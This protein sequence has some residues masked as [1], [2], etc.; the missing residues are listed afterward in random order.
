M[1]KIIKI[2]LLIFF[3]YQICFNFLLELKLFDNNEDFIIQ[4]IKYMD[5]KDEKNNLN[6]SEILE[7]YF[8]LKTNVTQNMKL[9]QNKIEKTPSVYI[10]NTHQKEGYQGEGLKEYNITPGV[11]MASYLF[12]A[13]LEENNIKTKILENNITEYMNLNNIKYSKSYKASR[14]FLEN[15][16]KENNYKLIIDLHR[17][18]VSKEKATTI[19]NKKS[20]AK[21]VFVVGL[22]HSKANANLETAKKLNELIKNKYPLLTRGVIEKKGEGVDG[23]YNQDLNENIIL[24]ELGTDKSTINE[25]LNTITLISPIIAE[26]VNE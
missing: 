23:I 13:K 24:L 11:F 10:Y 1:K 21:I 26:Y 9:V 3:L 20:C 14:Y 17:D 25:V 12:K 6:S 7:N 18:S 2:T 22:E 16:L 15:E 4:I 19:I 8:H 5:Y